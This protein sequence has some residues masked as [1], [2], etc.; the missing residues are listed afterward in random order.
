MRRVVVALGGNAILQPG[1][2]GTFSEQFDNVKK[3]SNE[4]IK[5]IDKGFKV[6]VTH[7]NGP[8]VGNILLQN[9]IAKKI[10]PPMPLFVCGAQSQGLIGIMLQQALREKLIENKIELSVATILTQVEVRDD[11]PAFKNPLKPIGPFYSEEEAREMIKQG[12]VMK[13]DAGRGWRRVVPSPDPID[14][15]EKHA[16]KQLLSNN[17]LVIACGGGG[18]PVVKDPKG[19]YKGVEAVIDK[20]LA[21][22]KLAESIDAELLIILTDVPKV[23]INYGKENQTDLGKVTAEEMRRYQREGHFKDGSMGPKVEA[24]LRFVEYKKGTAVI[25]ALD[26]CEEALKGEN[27]TVITS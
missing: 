7:G 5:L 25:T 23:A 10:V 18:I 21:A 22:E 15:V 24:A 3:A 6:V 16:L 27:G 14:I 4:I 26:K 13:E 9:E 17:T 12:V 8:Q 2:R 1:Q 19:N 20:D 11:D